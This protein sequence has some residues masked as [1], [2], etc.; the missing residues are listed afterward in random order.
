[1]RDNKVFSVLEGIY[2]REQYIG[3]E[4]IF[5]KYKRISK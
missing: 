4:K 2:S 5:R 3:K 1:M